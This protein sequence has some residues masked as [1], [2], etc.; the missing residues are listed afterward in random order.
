MKISEAQ[1]HEHEICLQEEQRTVGCH[2]RYSKLEY[3]L[4]YEMHLFHTLNTKCTYGL[5]NLSIS[6]YF[7]VLLDMYVLASGHS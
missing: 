5:F 1:K 7:C 3:K 2:S 4:E 6:S